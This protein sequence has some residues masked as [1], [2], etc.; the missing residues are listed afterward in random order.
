MVAPVTDLVNLRLKVI[1][2]SNLFTV[3]HLRDIGNAFSSTVAPLLFG[4]FDVA[5]DLVA[6]TSASAFLSEV[7]PL[8]LREVVWTV[9][10]PRHAQRDCLYSQGLAPRI[11]FAPCR[12]E[13]RESRRQKTG[14]RPMQE[15]Y[16]VNIRQAFA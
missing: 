3:R 16:N 9:D 13:F 14:P 1:C 12:F 4:F 7:C 10:S 8:F 11:A 6:R 5:M 15:V 2:G